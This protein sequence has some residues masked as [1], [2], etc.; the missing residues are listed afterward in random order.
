V[1]LRWLLEQPLQ[2][3]AGHTLLLGC[4]HIAQYHGA[5]FYLLLADDYRISGI[6]VV[7]LSQLSLEALVARRLYCSDA[8]LS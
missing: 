6:K 2:L 1:K 5:V 3:G 8:A 7:C 4:L